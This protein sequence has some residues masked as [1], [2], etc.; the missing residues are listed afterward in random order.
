MSREPSDKQRVFAMKTMV[1]AYGAVCIALSY[2][3]KYFGSV[4]QSALT[5]FG[6]IGGPVLAVFTLGILVP[7]VEQKVNGELTRRSR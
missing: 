2:A 3:A 5:V 6:V 1:L 7:Y 4:Y